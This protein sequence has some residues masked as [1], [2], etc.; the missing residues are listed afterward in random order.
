[1]PTVS[2]YEPLHTTSTRSAAACEARVLD[3]IKPLAKLAAMTMNGELKAID[4]MGQTRI[5]TA[6]AL[7]AW[8]GGRNRI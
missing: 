1:M 6:H 2:E 4:G 7:G 5:F 8:P 3:R